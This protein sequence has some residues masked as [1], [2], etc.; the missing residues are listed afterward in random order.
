M[1]LWDSPSDPGGSAEP[2]VFAMALKGE[3]AC[4]VYLH[5]QVVLVPTLAGPRPRPAQRLCR[6]PYPVPYGLPASA[7]CL[8]SLKNWSPFPIY[9][10]VLSCY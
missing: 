1:H 5:S 7:S 10:H 2:L 4:L 9:K 8:L 3:R 6:G